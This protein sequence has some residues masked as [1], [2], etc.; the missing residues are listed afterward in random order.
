ML[1][2]SMLNGSG[3]QSLTDNERTWYVSGIHDHILADI[4]M[5]D[6]KPTE[7]GV[8]IKWASGSTVGDYVKELTHL[9]RDPANI[10][11]PI[12]L[13]VNHCTVTLSGKTPK[14]VLT[15]RL[16]IL[17]DMATHLK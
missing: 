16:M 7:T 14:D 10:R 4:L 13:A 1:F 12:A 9:Y 15:A 2:R 8:G 6:Q 3:W 17:R 11:I 5:A